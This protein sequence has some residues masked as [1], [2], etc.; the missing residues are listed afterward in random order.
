MLKKTLTIATAIILGLLPTIIIGGI[1]VLI[2]MTKSGILPQLIAI[3]FLSGGFFLGY[4]VYKT[5]IGRGVIGF[6]TAVSASPD[7]DNLEPSVNSNHKKYNIA[8]Y[9]AAFQ[10]QENLFTTGGS[11]RIWGNYTFS[12]FNDFNKIE[13][14]QS[15]DTNQLQITFCNGNVLEVWDP[16]SIIEGHTYFKVL[17]CNRIEWIRT[18]DLKKSSLFTSFELQNNSIKVLSQ[19]NIAIS[20]NSFQPGE[21]AVVLFN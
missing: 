8:E 15:P 21:P 11:I 4:R 20:K 9:I 3:I 14:I 18:D 5:V 1:G 6:I 19:H 10:K 13:S 17:Y 7:L 12:G 2:I 16:K